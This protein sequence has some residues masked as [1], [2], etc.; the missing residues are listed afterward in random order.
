MHHI[1]VAFVY[2]HAVVLL[3]M[4][5]LSR[6]PHHF[7]LKRRDVSANASSKKELPDSRRRRLKQ[8]FDLENEA[9]AVGP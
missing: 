7:L 1:E 6:N 3:H 8:V 5:D 4:V 9:H 2:R